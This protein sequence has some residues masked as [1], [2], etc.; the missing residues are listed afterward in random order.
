[1]TVTSSFAFETYRGI[2]YVD[3]FSISCLLLD[4]FDHTFQMKKQRLII[5]TQGYL[6]VS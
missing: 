6:F 1:M 5:V 3:A 4:K 2:I